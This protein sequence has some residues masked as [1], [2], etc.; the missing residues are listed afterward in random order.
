MTN[1]SDRA[2][3]LV[4]FLPLDIDEAHRLGSC[5]QNFSR[6][7]R[8]TMPNSGRWRAARRR[9]FEEKKAV[10]GGTQM[11]SALSSHLR[12]VGK[13]ERSCLSTARSCNTVVVDNLIV[14]KRIM[15]WFCQMRKP[16]TNSARDG[17]VMVF[18]TDCQNNQSRARDRA[19]ETEHALLRAGK[20]NLGSVYSKDDIS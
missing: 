2:T 3:F 17:A 9:H 15:R 13:I 12:K 8:I 4:D 14:R 10:F 7:R 18:G 6:T 11:Q 1:P 5:R 19:V 20:S 16:A